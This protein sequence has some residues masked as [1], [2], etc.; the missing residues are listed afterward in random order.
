MQ[1]DHRDA[2]WTARSIGT[3]FG[4]KFFYLLIR[5]GGRQTAYFFLSFVVIFYVFFTPSIRKKADYYLSRRF[6]GKHFPGRLADSYRI[7]LNLGKALIDRAVIG[8][9]GEGKMNIEFR[10][11][12]ELLNLLKE[13]RGMVLMTAHVG[14]WQ[15]AMATLRFLNVPVHLLMQ[16]EDG[17]IDLHYYEHAGIP[18]P[19]RI[20]DPRGYMGGVLE[21]IGVLKK[22]EVIC[23]MGDRLLGSVKG[24][25]T[26]DFLGG[27]VLFP[28][29]AFKIAS[30]TGT[31]V[32]VLLS[33]KSSPAGY[34]LEVARVIRVPRDAGKS[35]KDF[36]SYVSEFAQALELYTEAH[37][38][39]FFNFYNMWEGHLRNQ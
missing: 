25:A 35:E 6:K 1:R 34:V 8:I 7:Y 21:M 37:P 36:S 9:L 5:F 39:Q 15:T 26:V 23:V 3:H 2:Q 16:R 18:C 33:H 20:I 22:G 31:P 13:G 11:Q 4:H 12:E 38:Y 14:C 30:A 10:K 32:A 24:A 29:S 17:D 28:F 27:K 19:Y